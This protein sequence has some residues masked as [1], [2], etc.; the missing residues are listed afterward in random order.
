[1][2][3]QVTPQNVKFISIFPLRVTYTANIIR[4]IIYQTLQATRKLTYTDTRN[5][6]ENCIFYLTPC[7]YLLIVGVKGYR[8][9]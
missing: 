8:C 5:T 4:N 9:A 6:H 7:T 1:M 2:P 3:L